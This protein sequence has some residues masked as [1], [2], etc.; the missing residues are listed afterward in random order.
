[1]KYQ[2]HSQT[3]YDAAV[4]AVEGSEN[5]K[6]RVWDFLKGRTATD[7]E[8]QQALGM[9]PSTQ[10]P[11]RIELVEAGLVEDSGETRETTAGRRAAIWRV[12]A[13]P[14]GRKTQQNLF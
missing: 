10:R 4:R 3:S 1:M 7:E 11:R 8:I 6:K 13:R 5:Q 9:N 14:S 12:R 2:A